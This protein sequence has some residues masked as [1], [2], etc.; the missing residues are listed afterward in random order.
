MDSY[1]GSISHNYT[2]YDE[3][4]DSLLA[5]VNRSRKLLDETIA[6]NPNITSSTTPRLF[7]SSFNTTN[8]QNTSVLNAS[9]NL[10]EQG[11][12]FKFEF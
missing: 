1:L 6:N 12:V 9:T 5:A 10:S 3:P 4:N 8:L 11:L 7:K 2:T